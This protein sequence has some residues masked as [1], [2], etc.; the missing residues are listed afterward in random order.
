MAARKTEVKE[1]E[2]ETAYTTDLAKEEII[3]VIVAKTQDMVKGP[4]RVNDPHIMH[5][6]AELYAAIK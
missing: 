4:D 2:Q 6:V 5:A 1:V 3:K